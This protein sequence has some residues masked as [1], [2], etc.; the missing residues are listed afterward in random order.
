MQVP[1]SFHAVDLQTHVEAVSLYAE[2]APIHPVQ[3]VAL[4]QPVQLVLQAIYHFFCK[5]KKL[6]I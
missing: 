1:P 6:I 3:A 5:N 2:S 4:V